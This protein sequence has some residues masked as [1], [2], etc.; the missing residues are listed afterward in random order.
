MNDDHLY[1]IIQYLQ[2]IMPED[3]VDHAKSVAFQFEPHERDIKV[4]ALLH[5]VVEDGYATLGELETR[6]NLSDEQYEA[7]SLLT[8]DVATTYSDYIDSCNWSKM[9]RRVKMADLVAN[10]AR[11]IHT[12]PDNSSLLRRYAKAYDKL[13]KYAKKHH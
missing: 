10:M 12:L 2:Y 3:A 9:A 7:L 6:F 4:V 13:S 5:D 11:C 8:R 1:T